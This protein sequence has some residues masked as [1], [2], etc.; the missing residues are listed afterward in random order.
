MPGPP[1]EDES[2][3]AVVLLVVASPAVVSAPELVGPPP[4]LLV[5]SVLP[6]SS[7]EDPAVGGGLTGRGGRGGGIGD[8]R[9]V[10]ATPRERAGACCSDP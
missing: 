5:S 10:A 9:V 2:G 6:A 8:G 7:L 1:L 4:V 3:S